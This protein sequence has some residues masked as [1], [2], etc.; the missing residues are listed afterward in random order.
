LKPVVLDKS[1]DEKRFQNVLGF[2]NVEDLGWLPKFSIDEGLLRTY[3]W[4]LK[5][6]T[7]YEL[8]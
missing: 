7:N 6:S 1:K 8:A 2:A 3:K 4:Y 5:Y